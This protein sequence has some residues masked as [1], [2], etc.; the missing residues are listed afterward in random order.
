MDDQLCECGEAA[1][2]V[3]H[4]MLICELYKEEREKLRKKA[5]VQGMRLKKLLGNEAIISDTV[6]FVE[7]TQRFDF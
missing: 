6:R 5:G 1:E 7:S 3:R 4:F 2:T